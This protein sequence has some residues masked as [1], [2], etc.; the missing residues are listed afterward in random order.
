MHTTNF[1]CNACQLAPRKKKHRPQAPFTADPAMKLL[2]T[3]VCLFVALAQA[4]N[5]LLPP[6]GK[7]C[8]F[9]NLKKNDELAVSFQVGSRDP[10]NAE[11]FKID[12]Y[13]S[14]RHRRGNAAVLTR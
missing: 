12:F 3:I 5:V 14:R 1:F 8:F 7:H 11:Q 13:V 10:H 9:E 4:H 6:H 2:L